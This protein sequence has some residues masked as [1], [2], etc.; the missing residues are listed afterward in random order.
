MALEAHCCSTPF[1]RRGHFRFSFL[2]VSLVAFEDAL[3]DERSK[4]P[5]ISLLD[6]W[7]LPINAPNAL[8]TGSRSTLT[9]L[10]K[11]PMGFARGQRIVQR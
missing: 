10:I 8:A 6:L 9:G 2:H 1:H 5:L 7:Q 11:L 3:V 4:M